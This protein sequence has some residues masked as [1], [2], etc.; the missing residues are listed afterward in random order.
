M[1]RNFDKEKAM[2]GL[3][4]LPF[5]LFILLA[6]LCFG[7]GVVGFIYSVVTYIA[8]ESPMVF[9]ILFGSFA[10][11][12]GIGMLL[13]DCFIRYKKKYDSKYVAEKV[14]EDEQPTTKIVE[15][16]KFKLDF[17][18]ICYGVMIV[19]A[20]FVLISAG[21]G[22][23]SSDNWRAETGDYRAS[24]GFNSTAK[25]YDLSYHKPVE[26]IIIDLDVKN[27][28]VKYTDDDYVMIRGYETFPGQM[29]SVYGGG[30]LKITD[31]S[32]PSLEGDTVAEMLGFMFKE[33]EAEA[34]IRLFVPL[35]QKDNIE[36]VGDYIVAQ[37]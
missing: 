29:T 20:V 27:V 28:V 2:K 31:N 16:K 19:G 14:D 13:V 4:I 36:I 7:I 25:I 15:K 8:F 23:I 35:S 9:L 30:T 21:L 24:K 17:Q 26:K 32:T 11:F 6:V 34:Q 10:L 22:A 18:T 12:V 33:N 3:A 37:E 5:V 1:G